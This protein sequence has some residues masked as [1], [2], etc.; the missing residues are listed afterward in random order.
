MTV[1]VDVEI[2]TNRADLSIA[3]LE[4]LYIR[5]NWK[6]IIIC[7]AHEESDTETAENNLNF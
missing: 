3:K 6:Q 1:T 2:N 4:K 7:W 5:N